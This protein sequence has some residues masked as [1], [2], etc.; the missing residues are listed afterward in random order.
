MVKYQ[1]PEIEIIICEPTN[2][3]TASTLYEE[4][5]STGGGAGMGWDSL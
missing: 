3:V 1:D 2:V 4:S 5:N